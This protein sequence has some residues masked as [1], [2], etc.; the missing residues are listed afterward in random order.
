MKKAKT[1]SHKKAQKAQGQ[2]NKVAF[3]W[4][5]LF[6]YLIW[7]SPLCASCASLWLTLFLSALPFVLL[8]PFC[9]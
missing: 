5:T 3:F 8:V 4:I 1:I 7:G 2:T 9:G 6:R